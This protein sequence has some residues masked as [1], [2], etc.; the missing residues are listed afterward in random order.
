M[1]I[2]YPPT[3]VGAINRLIRAKERPDPTNP[4]RFIYWTRGDLAKAAGIRPNTLTDLMRGDHE[5]SLTTLHRVAAALEVPLVV[6]LMTEAEAASYLHTH[7]RAEDL[8]IDALNDARAIETRIDLLFQEW[9]ARRTVAPR[10]AA[11]PKRKR[12]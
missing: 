12:A 11:E 4:A 6:L 5:P 8:A 2:S 1:T 3:W 10:E 7:A 9:S